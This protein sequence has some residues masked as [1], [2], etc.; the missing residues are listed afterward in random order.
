MASKV[1]WRCDECGGPAKWTMIRGAVHYWCKVC[2]VQIE[3]FEVVVQT[4]TLDGGNF[5]PDGEYVELEREE[6]G[7]PF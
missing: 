7:L 5:S 2:S 6:S 3:M 1:F 4:T